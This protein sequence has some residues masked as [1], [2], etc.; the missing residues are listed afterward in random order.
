MLMLCESFCIR[1]QHIVSL[2]IPLGAVLQSFNHDLIHSVPD[3]EQQ[4]AEQSTYVVVPDS[5][6]LDI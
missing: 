3:S 1:L 4:L 2:S 5:E 6:D